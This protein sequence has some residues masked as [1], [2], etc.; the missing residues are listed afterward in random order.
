MSRSAPDRCPISS[1][2]MVK[3]GISTREPVRRRT[4]SAL[5]ASRRTG[6]AMVPASR[7]DSTSMTLSVTRNTL[8][9]PS[10]SAVTMLSMSGP[11]V[12][13]IR[14]PRTARKR[15]T[16]NATDTITSPR[17]LIRTMLDLKPLRAWSTSS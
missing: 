16:G 11:W 5:P 3:S 15:C 4:I 13:S 12:E 14:A 2:R 17:S 7:N 1:R 6:P 8:K 10:R 9:L